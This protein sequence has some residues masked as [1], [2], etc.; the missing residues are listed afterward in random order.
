MM[1]KQDRAADFGRRWQEMAGYVYPQYTF[2]SE[3]DPEFA[4]AFLTIMSAWRREGPIPAKYKEMMIL[5]GSCVK[6]QDMAIRTHLR[7]ARALG[8]TE[9]ELL[10]LFEVV[11]LSGG[12]VAMVKALGLFM[13][14]IGVVAEMPTGPAWT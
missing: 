2:L 9:D 5:M 7:K 3:R 14:E 6:M 11:L 13:E 12:G 1:D 4:E 8:A 10:E